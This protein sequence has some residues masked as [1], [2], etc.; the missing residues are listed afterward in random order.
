MS[1]ESVMPSTILSPSPPAFYLCQH[2]G[3]FQWV[4]SSH[5]VAKV[6]E[7]QHRPF[8]WIF[9]V[10]FLYAW[11]VN[12]LVVQGTLKNLLQKHSSN[13]STIWC[14][15]FFMVQLSHPYMTTG[16][17]IALTRQTFVGKV[18]S[19][20]F[21]TLSRLSSLRPVKSTSWERL[22]L[23]PTFVKAGTQNT[24]GGLLKWRC[25]CF[26]NVYFLEFQELQCLYP[27][28]LKIQSFLIFKCSMLKV[29]FLFSW[30]SL[31]V[32]CSFRRT[33][34]VSSPWVVLL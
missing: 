3:L 21:N 1:I 28:F 34:W 30:F 18:M 9:R 15:V 31:S 4:C 13:A 32:Q 5:Q 16:K 10:D 23:R 8:Q 17:T 6:L 26:S 14:S 11:L 22:L 29:A 27:V 24:S 2:R 20:L 33:L 12:L 19:L 7:L 25:W